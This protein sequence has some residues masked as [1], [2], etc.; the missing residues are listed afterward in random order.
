M[1][2]NSLIPLGVGEL[3]LGQDVLGQIIRQGRLDF[4]DFQRVVVA[5]FMTE[6]AGDGSG[7]S[8]DFQDACGV[9]SCLERADQSLCQTGGTW[10][11]GPGDTGL[12]Q[13]GFQK[14]PVRTAL[15]SRRVRCVVLG[16]R[17]IHGANRSMAAVRCN[18]ESNKPTQQDSTI[19][20]NGWVNDDSA[21]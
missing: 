12:P 21:R 6:E 9:R 19:R 11:D 10:R 20:R 3:G 4:A 5:H 8:P 15:R 16:S 1:K 7:S 13:E 2:A 14:N 18:R 17:T